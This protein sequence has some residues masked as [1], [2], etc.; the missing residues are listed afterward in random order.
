M[1]KIKVVTETTQV[2]V[3]TSYEGYLT[4]DGKR[5]RF[6]IRFKAP[7]LKIGLERVEKD[8]VLTQ[9]KVRLT[10][11]SPHRGEVDLPLASRHFLVVMLSE[12]CL[13]LMIDILAFRDG[14][15][16]QDEDRPCSITPKKQGELGV[17]RFEIDPSLP[18][19]RGILGRI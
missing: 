12:A 19:V 11:I 18:E 16:W 5:L 6:I 7:I 8:Y 15:G 17:T 1:G 2:E 4:L 13:S 10:L 9:N 14:E 3:S